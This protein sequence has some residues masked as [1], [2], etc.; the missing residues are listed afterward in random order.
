MQSTA[1]A[2]HHVVDRQVVRAP[3]AILAGEVVANKDFAAGQLDLCSWRA[4][5][6]DQTNYRWI[7]EGGGG[8][9]DH[10]LMRFE[11]F[12]FAAYDEHNRPPAVADV[13]RLVVLIQYQDRSI[14]GGNNPYRPRKSLVTLARGAGKGPE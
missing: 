5:Q 1:G 14:H 13:Q 9:N 7:G 4:N 6:I 8:C 3:A 12:S 10:R 2:G 11:H